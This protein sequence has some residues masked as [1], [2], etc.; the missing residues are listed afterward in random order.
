MFPSNAES[1]SI[2]GDAKSSL[3][4]ILVIMMSGGEKTASKHGQRSQKGGKYCRKK[5]CT[6]RINHLNSFDW[7]VFNPHLVAH[8]LVKCLSSVAHL[9]RAKHRPVDTRSRQ[10]LTMLEAMTTQLSTVCSNQFIQKKAGVSHPF[11]IYCRNMH[12]PH[13]LV[14]KP[15]K[16]HNFKP[17][18]S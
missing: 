6:N 16:K 1:R 9:L 14:A 2:K 18:Y 17:N 5:I 8:L 4:N 15:N 3:G 11:L 7:L 13:F 12:I 10:Y